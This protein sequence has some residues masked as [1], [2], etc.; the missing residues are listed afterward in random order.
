MKAR[1]AEHAEACAVTDVISLNRY[2]KQV[3]IYL[4]YLSSPCQYLTFIHLFG[5]FLR[6]SLSELQFG[7][8][9]HRTRTYSPEHFYIHSNQTAQFVHTGRKCRGL[10]N[11]VIFKPDTNQVKP[12]LD[13]QTS[14]FWFRLSCL[15]SHCDPI[16]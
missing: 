9:L 11:R 8:I 10:P 6:L 5:F 15:I 4:L 2:V 7:C 13:V 12:P 1:A 14:S 16:V 3:F